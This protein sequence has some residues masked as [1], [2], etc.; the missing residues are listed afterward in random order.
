MTLPE[1]PQDYRR[2][3][4]WNPAIPLDE[5]GHAHVTLWNNSSPS[6]ISVEAEGQTTDGK[7]LWT[8]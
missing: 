2:T 1:M 5:K 7:L 3:L 8:K 4:Y 6:Q